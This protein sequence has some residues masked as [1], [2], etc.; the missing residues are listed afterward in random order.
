MTSLLISPVVTTPTSSLMRW[1]GIPYLHNVACVCYKPSLQTFARSVTHQ[2][3][4]KRLLTY[5]SRFQL[6]FLPM[7]DML[8]D[9]GH[10]TC[11]VVTSMIQHWIFSCTFACI[12]Y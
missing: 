7:Y 10:R 1:F 9:I 2:P 12:N 3:L 11:H 8:V 5:R 4:I 6:V